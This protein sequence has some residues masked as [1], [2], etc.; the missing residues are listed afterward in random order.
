MK[1]AKP[2]IEQVVDI[3]MEDIQ[4][5]KYNKTLKLPAEKKLANQLGVSRTTLRT[6]LARLE[7]EGL[8]TRRQGDGTFVNKRALERGIRL[9][10]IWDFRYMIES[11]GRKVKVECLEISVRDPA[12]E[13]LE[14]LELKGGDLVMV[15]ER[16]YYG[17][18]KPV[19]HSNNYFPYKLSKSDVSIDEIDFNLPIHELLGKYF[20]QEIAYSVSDIGAVLSKPAHNPTLAIQSG[21]P[22]FEFHDVFYNA[23]E[24]PLMYGHNFLNDKVFQL[25]VAHSWG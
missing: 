13:I 15:L 22:I 8:V 7:S 11:S 19:I 6:A 25:R 17:D 12:P 10:G 24:V 9:G 2:V 14:T 20:D 23:Y 21:T 18:E 3:L 5:G 1:R 16:L 4:S